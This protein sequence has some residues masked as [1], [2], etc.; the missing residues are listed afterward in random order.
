MQVQRGK[1]YRM[2]DHK[3]VANDWVRENGVIWMAE[4]DEW[5]DNDAARWVAEFRSVATGRRFQV[6]RYE[7]WSVGLEELDG[8][9]T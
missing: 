5:R 9:N 1:L 4:R 6:S 2:T 7:P 3:G 8:G